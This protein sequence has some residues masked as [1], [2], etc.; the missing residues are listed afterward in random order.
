MS[1]LLL[2]RELVN[3]G[4]GWKEAIC[5]IYSESRVIC[6]L[7]WV[8]SLEKTGHLNVGTFLLEALLLDEQFA[9]IC[10]FSV[11]WKK[12]LLVSSVFQ[13][14]AGKLWKIDTKGNPFDWISAIFVITNTDR[15]VYQLFLSL[16]TSVSDRSLSEELLPLLSCLLITSLQNR[17]VH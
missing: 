9:D 14:D 6:S 2:M 15:G 3:C 16:Q 4:W 1:K 8:F 13:R 11:W 5:G 17:F 7:I 10:E 12:K